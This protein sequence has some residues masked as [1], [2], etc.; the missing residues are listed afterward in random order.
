[1]RAAH[2]VWLRL[3]ALDLLHATRHA[4]RLAPGVLGPLALRLRVGER[5]RVRRV[6]LGSRGRG[7]VVLGEGHNNGVLSE[8]LQTTHRRHVFISPKD[9]LGPVTPSRGDHRDLRVGARVSDAP[10]HALRISDMSP[11]PLHDGKSEASGFHVRAYR[12]TY[13]S[14]HRGRSPP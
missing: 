7:Q 9:E 13:P 8:A 2:A 6:V 12:E 3:V 5:R 1:M 4:A 11:L 14:Q 10:D